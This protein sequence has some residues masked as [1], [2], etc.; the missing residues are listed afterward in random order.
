MAKYPWDPREPR[1]WL[2]YLAYLIFLNRIKPDMRPEA[3]VLLRLIAV[4]G[5]VLCVLALVA[6]GA[7]EHIGELLNHWPFIP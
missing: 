5:I 7:P 4:V 2:D 3:Q 6:V 1:D